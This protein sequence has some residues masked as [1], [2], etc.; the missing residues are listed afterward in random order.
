MPAI[1]PSKQEQALARLVN[2][3]FD[4]DLPDTAV[5]VRDAMHAFFFAG[6]R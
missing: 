4:F 3:N 5:L 2:L 6:W 1:V